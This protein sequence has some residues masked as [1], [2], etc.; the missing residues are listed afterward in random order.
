MAMKRIHQLITGL[1]MLVSCGSIAPVSLSRPFSTA[2]TAPNTA[3]YQ[4]ALKLGYDAAAKLNYGKALEYFRHA[5]KLRPGDRNAQTAIAN[6]AQHQKSKG[7]RVTP[8]GVGAPRDR[9]RAGTRQQNCLDGQKLVAIIPDSE[10]GLTSLAQPY[11]TD[12]S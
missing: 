4:Q 11:S 5:L 12:L 7:F 1:M 8:S 2:Q 3:S 10:L 6:T 9:A